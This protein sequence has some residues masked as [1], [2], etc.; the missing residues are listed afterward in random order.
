MTSTE[1]PIPPAADLRGLLDAELS[2]RSRLG[3]VALL[4]TSAA[5]TAVVTS[6]WLT[7]P[8]L[9]GRT[10]VAFAVMT[11]IGL[12][13]MA[14]SGWV[15]TRRRPILGRDRVVAGRLAVTFTSVFV[16]GALAAGYVSGGAAPYAALVMGLVLLA[17]A[18]VAL[19]RARRNVARLTRRR[20]ALERE[21]G[22]AI[23]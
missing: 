2:L 10:A 20:D 18:G 1:T 7:E 16:V 22:T 13:W 3:Y 11:L 5:M 6:L 14:F 19:V 4:L 9:P 15:L 8:V 23:G 12:S 21:L 17:V